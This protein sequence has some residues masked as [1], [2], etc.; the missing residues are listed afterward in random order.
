MR[1]SLCTRQP[2]PPNTPK[3]Q[4]QTPQPRTRAEWLA[5]F[6]EANAHPESR[7]P[8][9]EAEWAKLVER[10]GCMFDFYLSKFFRPAKPLTTTA[11]TMTMT[12]K[13]KGKGKGGVG[14]GEKEDGERRYVIKLCASKVRSL[15][16]VFV[17]GWCVGVYIYC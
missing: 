5:L 12:G 7:A 9:F 17:C 16:L 15:N 10:D 13:K 6:R 1:A 2:H 14:G 4:P 3:P 11:T 8:G